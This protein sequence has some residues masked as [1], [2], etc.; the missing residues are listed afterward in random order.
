M[1]VHV[2]NLRYQVQCFCLLL[3]SHIDSKCFI[4]SIPFIIH[5]QNMTLLTGQA[6]TEKCSVF[7]CFFLIFFSVCV[8]AHFEQQQIVLVHCSGVCIFVGA[9][10]VVLLGGP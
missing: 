5:I 8:Q 9:K 10:L 4:L 3:E 7:C 6:R 2:Q 1:K